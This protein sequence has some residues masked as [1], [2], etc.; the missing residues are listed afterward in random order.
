MTEGALL[1]GNTRSSDVWMQCMDQ[2]LVGGQNGYGIRDQLIKADANKSDNKMG[3][4]VCV[5]QENCV[6]LQQTQG[7]DQKTQALSA[8]ARPKADEG[9]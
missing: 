9:L 8:A 6:T 4:Q 1:K 2:S 7:K 5:L 3:W